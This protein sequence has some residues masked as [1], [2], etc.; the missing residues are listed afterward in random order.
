MQRIAKLKKLAFPLLT[1]LTVVV[2][3][4]SGEVLITSANRTNSG[5]TNPKSCTLVDGSTGSTKLKIP[6]NFDTSV[7]KDLGVTNSSHSGNSP[8]FSLNCG[9]GD[10]LAIQGL[11]LVAGTDIPHLHKKYGGQDNSNQTKITIASEDSNGDFTG[12]Y[13]EISPSVGGTYP[14]E[15]GQVKSSGSITFTLINNNDSTISYTYTGTINS[16]DGS[17]SGTWMNNNN[18]ST[19]NWQASPQDISLAPLN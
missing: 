16:D 12:I 15:R 19:G 7:A 13:N 14:I 18:S 17:M 6:K 10:T 11:P 2:T 3:T 9:H 8:N 4:F 5:G 1:L